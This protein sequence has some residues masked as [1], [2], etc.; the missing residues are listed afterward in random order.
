MSYET[1]LYDWPALAP[2]Y[3]ALQVGN[4]R[5][6]GLEDWVL[7]LTGLSPIGVFP[8]VLRG[9]NP[10]ITGVKITRLTTGRGH[11]FQMSTLR[12]SESTPARAHQ[13]AAGGSLASSRGLRQDSRPGA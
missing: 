2:S 8:Y 1:M 13:G 6:P 12:S 10:S 3:P 11:S 4:C 5:A 9:D 7:P